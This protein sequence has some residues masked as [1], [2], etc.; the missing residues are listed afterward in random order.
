MT[1]CRG[2]SVSE[3]RDDASTNCFAMGETRVGRETERRGSRQD[4]G[5]RRRGSEAVALTPE[6]TIRY[7][8]LIHVRRVPDATDQDNWKSGGIA[9]ALG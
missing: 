5:K 3:Y 4:S 9:S 1:A 6:P 8:Y 7:V 2:N